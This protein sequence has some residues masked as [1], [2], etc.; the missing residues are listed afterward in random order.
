MYN[1]VSIGVLHFLGQFLIFLNIVEELLPI[2]LLVSNTQCIR[3]QATFLQN[4]LVL[5][6]SNNNSNLQSILF[7][8]GFAS[9][10]F[11]FYSFK[12]LVVLYIH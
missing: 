7:H 12:N 5:T 3:I 4:A 2:C 9:E 11:E 6:R 10:F 1:A 8:C